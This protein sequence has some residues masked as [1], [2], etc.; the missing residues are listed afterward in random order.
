MKYGIHACKISC[1]WYGP[2][3]KRLLLEQSFNSFILVGKK[4]FRYM[5]VGIDA[6]I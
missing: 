6:P 3:R 5:T 2:R 1:S 4:Y